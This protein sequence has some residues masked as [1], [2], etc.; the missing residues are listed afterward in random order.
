MRMTTDK[1][2]Q[3]EQLRSDENL[4]GVLVENAVLKRLNGIAKERREATAKAF[5]PGMKREIVNAQGVKM[6]SVSMSRPNKRVVPDDQS[7]L[8][9]AAQDAGCEL[10]ERLPDNDTP[11]AVEIINIITE[12]GRDDLLTIGISNKEEEELVAKRTEQWGIDGKVPTG[13]HVEDASNPRF[14]VTPGRTKPA[15]AALD[16]VLS[17][18]QSAF[19]LNFTGELAA[20][21]RK[22]IEG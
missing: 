13:W 22:E 10:I 20:D 3:L 11:E 16:H 6:G 18:V 21:D 15:K 9:G 4:F 12:A 5:E 2:K 14:S 1:D 19:G 8:L 17:E 7:V